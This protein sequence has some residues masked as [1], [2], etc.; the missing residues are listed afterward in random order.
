[1][2]GSASLRYLAIASFVL[3][4]W[5]CGGG[6][7]S[8]TSEP[9][10]GR[11]AAALPATPTE[12]I[13][14]TPRDTVIG[15]V[16]LHPTCSNAAGTDPTYHFYAR[17]G[18][19]SGLMVFFGGGGACWDGD[20]CARPTS[21]SQAVQEPKL[22]F[23]EVGGDDPAK[24]GGVL[25]PA[26]PDS[27]VRDWSMVYV[28]SCNGDLHT[29]AT[30]TTYAHPTSGQPYTIEHR[31]AD[32]VRVV[33]EWAKDNFE[34]P[35][36]LFVLGSSAG[37]IGALMHYPALRAAYPSA[38]AALMIESSP[39]VMPA[40]FESDYRRN[41]NTA[42]DPSIWGAEAAT[43]PMAA[44]MKPLAAHYPND[45][46][47][48]YTAAADWTLIDYYARMK[49][50][51]QSTVDAAV[52]SAWVG[53]MAAQITDNQSAPNYR[54]YVFAGTSHS[55]MGWPFTPTTAPV[56]AWT[57]RMLSPSA[58]GWTNV[59]CS[60]CTLAAYCPAN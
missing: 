9:P 54:S 46:F 58:E 39:T 15:G 49:N 48:Q 10:P 26:D 22:Y 3:P 1:M 14:F 37:G 5:S 7:D 17:R 16:P 51:V 6:G 38:R 36:Q 32:N 59:P 43:T 24:Y 56:A 44:L 23:A 28:P 11:V 41:W 60:D 21:G 35:D 27:P 31:G 12:W 34:R 2:T 4:L 57:S 20:S 33:L 45:R 25:N 19:G 13:K 55:I 52:C 30:S 47:S 53:D 50:G 42:F 8:S 18:S 29:G 40:V